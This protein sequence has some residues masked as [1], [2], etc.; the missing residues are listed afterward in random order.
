[1][2]DTIEAGR[3]RRAIERERVFAGVD[4]YKRPLVAR[5]GGYQCRV[6]HVTPVDEPDTLKLL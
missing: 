3:T 6:V 1:M 4:D 5:Q 2:H